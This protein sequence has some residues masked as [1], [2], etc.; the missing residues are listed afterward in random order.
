M[1][2]KASI[3]PFLLAIGEQEVCVTGPGDFVGHRHFVDRIQGYVR[4]IA[5]NRQGL[6]PIEELL[7]LGR[8]LRRKL[9]TDI[10][11]SPATCCHEVPVTDST[12]GGKRRLRE[13]V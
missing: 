10:V 2:G 4:D 12:D 8:H 3:I 7:A 9:R 5:G 13:I 6:D 1:V 11:A